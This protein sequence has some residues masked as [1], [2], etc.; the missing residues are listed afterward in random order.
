M[1]ARVFL[2]C[3][4]L[5]TALLTV[6]GC[7]VVTDSSAPYGRVGVALT[8]PDV[9]LA[10]WQAPETLGDYVLQGSVQGSQQN[11]R[12][13]RYINTTRPEE[14]LELSIYPIPG[15][16]EDLPP[17]RMVEGHFPQSRE[18]E[19]R[20][21]QRYS[22]ADV[23]EIL[24]QS[25]TNDALKYPVAISEVHSRGGHQPMSSLLM[26]SADKPVFLRLHLHSQD[27]DVISRSDQMLQLLLAFRDGLQRHDK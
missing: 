4:I 23:E 19:L 3:S 1:T 17:I 18:A 13:F 21:L 2:L 15:G 20:R 6:T 26:L 12:L 22:Q 7:M 27:D 9:D 25:R 8:D 16:W 10:L 14:I 11:L 5:L 24:H